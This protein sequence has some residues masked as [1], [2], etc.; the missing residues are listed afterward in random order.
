MSRLASWV[1]AM[2]CALMSACVPQAAGYSDVRSAVDSKLHK[3]I[4][5]YHQDGT[6]AAEKQIRSLVKEPLTAEAAVQ[7]ALLN[8]PEVQVEFERIG[9]ARADLVAA[10]KLPNP[11]IGADAIFY[12][13][14]GDPELALDATLSLTRLITMSS[15]VKSANASLDRAKAEVLAAA[16]D[17]SFKVRRA[18]TEYQLRLASLAL[19]RKSIG[20][21][22][23]NFVTA[24]RMHAAGNLSDLELATEQ[25][26][27][28]EARLQLA[29]A[30]QAER[31]AKLEL[32]S[33][34]GFWQRGTDFR[35]ATQ[36][37]EVPPEAAGVERLSASQV[38]AQ[39]LKASLDL[40]ITRRRRAEHAQRANAAALEGALPDL[41]AGVGVERQEAGWGIGPA[42]HLELPLF[43]Q[44]QGRVGR[45]ESALR[46]LSHQSLATASQIRAAARGLV[47]QLVSTRAKVRYYRD[48]L[49][50]LRQRVSQQTLL[51]YN[52]MSV[53]VFQ[54]ME[55]RRAELAA[56][57]RSLAAQ[58]DY[59]VARSRLE[60]LL[61]GR[62]P[63]PGA[64]GGADGASESGPSERSGGH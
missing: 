60:Q 59:W 42:V 30:E 48:V 46:Q 25:V 47:Q 41:G 43:D 62:L 37:T 61:A 53:G 51:E 49:V 22:N 23:V 18:F 24:E 38:E 5:W 19:L 16:V 35:V 13:H 3:D 17:L 39:A 11:R 50:P 6:A 54:L 40:E 52:A 10:W 21:A 55:A 27:Y 28:E 33:L 63:V 20:A 1:A 57:R 15:R 8:N 64:A 31:A 2:A 36:V 9:M 29:D 32:G 45:E 4:R 44:G 56:Q 14:P 7:I 58:G 34:L 12:G 26:L